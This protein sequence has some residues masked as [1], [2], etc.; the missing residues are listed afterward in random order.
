MARKCP[1]CK[2]FNVRRSAVR[3]TRDQR[4]HWLFSP[5]RCRDCRER[6]WVISR[7]TSAYLLAGALTATL[8]IGVFG[9]T[10]A[11]WLQERAAHSDD[12]ASVS[13]RYAELLKLA[14]KDDAA[15]EYELAQVYR[16]S[17]DVAPDEQKEF[18]WLE[19]AAKHGNAPA[20]Y[21]LG[22][23]YRVGQG[24]IQDYEQA[25]KWIR[26]AAERG[27][28]RAQYE[29]GQMYRGGVGVKAD[30]VLAYIWLN[31]AAS[32]GIAGAAA[33]RDAV[34]SRLSA[35]E[36]LDAQLRSRSLGGMQMGMTGAGK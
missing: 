10:V 25:L 24:T 8:V 2:S 21:E 26:T 19:R 30:N 9:W 15:A 27:D 34:G 35:S 28:G 20:Q 32:Q 23:A 18:R 12:I 16:S 5:Y 4:R 36:V 1:K 22:I 31:L 17:E 33:M 29:L 7:T 6:F 11:D 14:E 13:P 3:S